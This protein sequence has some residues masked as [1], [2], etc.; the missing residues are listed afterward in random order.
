LL[1]GDPSKARRVLEWEPRVK[2]AELVEMMVGIGLRV[3]MSEIGDFAKRRGVSAR[4]ILSQHPAV[5]FAC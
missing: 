1:L 3:I 5:F 2:F 4:A